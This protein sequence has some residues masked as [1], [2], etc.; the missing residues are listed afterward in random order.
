MLAREQL[1]ANSNGPRVA[2]TVGD[3]DGV[4]SL[5]ET[6]SR[7]TA[8][9]FRNAGYVTRPLFRR[10]SNPLSLRRLL[11]EADV[12]LWEG[13]ASGLY[14]WGIS[15]WPEP[16]RP[17]LVFLQSCGGLTEGNCLPFLEHGAIGV[18]GS[19]ARTFSATG[20]ALAMAYFDALL[21]DRQS[22]G[23]A[24]RQAKNFLLAYAKL[25]EQRLGKGLKREGANVRSAWAYTLWGDPTLQLPRPEPPEDAMPIVQTRVQND[26]ISIKLPLDTYEKVITNRYQA[27]LRPNGRLAGLLTKTEGQTKKTLVPLLFSEV[28][29]PEAPAGKAP[30]LSSRVPADRWVFL[31]DGRLRTGYLLVQPRVRDGDDIRF[32]VVWEG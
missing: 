15:R 10:D 24:M 31:W 5:L 21:Y 25:K 17:A 6:I 9:E 8:K 1:L 22:V 2:V 20:G 26:L 4:L 16:L 13:H 11:P 19:P 32:S 23:G 29:L 12:F 14:G 18:I 28:R 7:N 27:A 30:R 3:P